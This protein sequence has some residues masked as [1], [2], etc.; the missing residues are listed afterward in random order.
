M[1]PQS[2][3]LR[4]LFADDDPEI[5][6]YFEELLVRLG[7]QPTT[8]NSG[9]ELINT[10]REIAPDLIITDVVMPDLDGIAAVTEIDRDQ[11]IPVILV[12]AHE[13]PELIHRASSNYVMN[14]LIKPVREAEVQA[15]IN[16]AMLRFR[17]YQA[18]HQEANNL[19]Q[20]LENRKLLERAKGAVM[21]RLRVEEDDAF[22]RMKK[23]ASQSNR[24]LI[25]VAR[26]IVNAEQVFHGLENL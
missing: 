24:K 20:A 6:E 22:G 21:K 11:P 2:P 19:R 3:P 25:D 8:V 14:Y 26:D 4:I 7:H 13:D 10:A 1:K 12:S 16:V 18:L 17:Q 9:R 15:A 5:R 23:L